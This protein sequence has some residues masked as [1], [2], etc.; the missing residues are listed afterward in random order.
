M[1]ATLF[2]IVIVISFLTIIE[3]QAITFDFEKEAQ[4]NNWK[5]LGGKW[6]VEDGA[7]VG[8]S[9]EDEA[10]TYTGEASWKL[11]TIWGKIRNR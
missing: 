4:A 10:T 2:S 9:N 7:Y 6:K 3:A 5:V 11:P 8:E 1:K